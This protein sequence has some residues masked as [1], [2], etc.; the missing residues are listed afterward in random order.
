MIKD[1]K[2]KGLKKLFT[3]NDSS[4]VQPAHAKKLR[5]LLF[6]L[7][8]AET[9]QDMDFAGTNLHSLHGDLK[10]HWSVKVSGNWRM[11]FAFE[12]GDAYI[13]DYQDYH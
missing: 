3:K 9:I 6:R 4:G 12:N 7:N 11:T 13:V 5:F 8:A 10:G 2:H 1:F